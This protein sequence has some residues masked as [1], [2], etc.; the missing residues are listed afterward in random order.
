MKIRHTH[1]RDVCTMRNNTRLTLRR[2][3]R[4]MVAFLH[5]SR[6]IRHT[7][8]K[9]AS[10][11]RESVVFCVLCVLRTYIRVG[12]RVERGERF[13][14]H[15]GAEGAHT[16]YVLVFCVRITVY[17]SLRTQTSLHYTEGI[18][19]YFTINNWPTPLKKASLFGALSR[20][21]TFAY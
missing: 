7:S 20:G 13:T 17:S 6:Y 15:R 16:H 4:A 14:S 3:V 5:S 12:H 10:A 1:T 9:S 8:H 11:M 18:L 2:G 19:D 21:R